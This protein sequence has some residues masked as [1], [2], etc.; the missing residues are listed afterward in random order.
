MEKGGTRRKRKVAGEDM[1][2]NNNTPVTRKVKTDIAAVRNRQPIQALNDK[3]QQYINALLDPNVATIIATGVLGSSKTW[4]PSALAA[5]LLMDNKLERVV[6]ARPAEGKAKSVG[7]TKGDFDQKLAGWC[8]PIL[9][10]MKQRMGLGNFEAALE[11][12]KIVLLPLEQVKGRSWDDTWL[13]ADEVEDIEQETAKSLVTRM[14]QRSKII[15]AGDV[16]QQ[17]LKRHS[18]LQYILSVARTLDLP[19]TLIDFNDWKYCVRSEEAK[20]WGMAF[21]QYDEMN[22]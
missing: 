6:V 1:K 2:G 13:I 21:E 14:G 9:D 10:T 16:A 4:L 8:A 15:L 20:M 7:F 12:G 5:D 22:K 17:D 19:V 11:F 18:G 3:Q